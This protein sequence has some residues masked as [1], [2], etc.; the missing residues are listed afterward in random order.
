VR[1][2][3]VVKTLYESS[4]FTQLGKTVGSVLNDGKEEEEDILD[5]DSY[6]Q[7]DEE[8]DRARQA[9][10]V[11]EAI[12]KACAISTKPSRDELDG[13]GKNGAIKKRGKGA[14]AKDSILEQ[15]LNTCTVFANPEGDDLAEERHLALHNS[16]EDQYSEYDETATG[17][18]SFDTFSDED[19]FDERKGRRRPKQR[20]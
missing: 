18:G 15:V 8:S 12:A 5:G 17:P 2:L 14:A 1:C 13:K 10:S 3:K 16:T 9:E 6:T 19:D 20:R 11:F 7:R 4:T